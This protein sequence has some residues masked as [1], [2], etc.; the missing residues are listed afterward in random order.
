[1][2]L[3]IKQVQIDCDNISTISISQLYYEIENRIL[4]DHFS[5]EFKKSKRYAIIGASGTG[6]TTLVK[7]ILNYYPKN[8]LSIFLYLFELEL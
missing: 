8:L 2:E 3:S 1:M 5:Y 4:F 6:K 7:L